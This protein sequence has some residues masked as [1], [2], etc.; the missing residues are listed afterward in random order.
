MAV[1]AFRVAVVQGVRGSR[2][3]LVY[4][5]NFDVLERTPL[6]RRE[7]PIL[8]ELH[9]HADVRRDVAR[10]HL[11]ARER[12]LFVAGFFTT[13]L[14]EQSDIGIPILDRRQDAVDARRPARIRHQW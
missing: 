8:L 5:H 12:F 6:Q 13:C 7:R 11:D 4:L 10:R 14:E 2:L 9:I 3:A 1:A